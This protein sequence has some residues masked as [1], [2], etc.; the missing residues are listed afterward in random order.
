MTNGWLGTQGSMEVPADEAVRA[1]HKVLMFDYTNTGRQNALEKNTRDFV[2]ALDVVPKGLK[3]RALGVSMG[4][5]VQVRGLA[6]TKKSVEIATI[7]ASAGFIPRELYGWKEVGTHLAATA[8]ELTRIF[9]SDPARAIRLGATTVVHCA[10]RNQA[11]WGEFGELIQGDEHAAVRR[12][13]DRRK[14]PYLR[15][16]G[17]DGDHLFPWLLQEA[18][19]A[20]LPFDH[21][22]KYHGGHT[23]LVHDPELSRHIFELDA[24]LAGN[25]LLRAA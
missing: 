22:E 17:G 8:P 3:R 1:G 2:A 12:I 14:A 13:K 6:Q 4:G 24:E 7:V 9:K 21:T 10:R 11:V 18:A 23:R 20:G 19:V 16:M 25:H 5:R 15:F